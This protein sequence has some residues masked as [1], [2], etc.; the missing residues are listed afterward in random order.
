MELYF[1]IKNQKCEGPSK[2]KL[3]YLIKFEM[4]IMYGLIQLQKE[5]ILTHFLTY[6]QYINIKF[7]EVYIMQPIHFQGKSTNFY[8]SL[9]FIDMDK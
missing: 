4:P 6:I 3:T 5:T 1:S 8:V 9:S 7:L 2:P